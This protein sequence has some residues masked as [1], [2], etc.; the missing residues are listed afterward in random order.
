METPRVREHGDLCTYPGIPPHCRFSPQDGPRLQAWLR[1]TGH[2]HRVAS[3]LSAHTGSVSHP[4]ACG[5][6]GKFTTCSLM[7][8]PPP[9]PGH[10]ETGEE[11]PCRGWAPSLPTWGIPIE[12]RLQPPAPQRAKAWSPRSAPTSWLKSTLGALQ[13][14][15]PGLQRHQA[16][17]RAL[18]QLAQQLHR[19]SL[20]SQLLGPE[21]SQTF[22]TICG[23][24]DTAT[25]LAQG[26]I[27][28]TLDAK[29][30]PPATQI[31]SAER[32]E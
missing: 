8:Q 10:Q 21:E 5:G 18:E 28:A 27:S 14:R 20:L 26:P 1:H 7:W 30:K 29:P 6:D 3:C 13:Q 32:S 19:E 17:L 31:P 2:E 15:V 9:S 23:R 11:V 4:A 16:Q 25:V 22:S 24:P 12:L